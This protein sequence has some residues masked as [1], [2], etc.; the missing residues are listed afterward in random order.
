M[1]DCYFSKEEEPD[2][3]AAKVTLVYYKDN[4]CHIRQKEKEPNLGLKQRHGQ[5]GYCRYQVAA[6]AV[7]ALNHAAA[8]A[9]AA[10]H[11]K[12]T[13]SAPQ[14]PTRSSFMS[15]GWEKMEEKMILDNTTSDKL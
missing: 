3:A 10:Q 5:H 11:T 2:A 4:V 7:A 1:F 9:D 13:N 8:D 12:S 6:D 15:D 14:T